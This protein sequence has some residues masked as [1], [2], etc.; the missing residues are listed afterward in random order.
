LPAGDFLID[1][2]DFLCDDGSMTYPRSH[3][4]SEEKPGFYHVVSRCVRRA[5]LCGKDRLTGCSFEHRRSWIE[6][7][8]LELAEGSIDACPGFGAAG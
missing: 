6:D 5:F 2:D 4:V 1:I 3:L 8:I 7:R